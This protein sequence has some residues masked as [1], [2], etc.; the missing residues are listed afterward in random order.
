MDGGIRVP[1]LFRWPGVIHPGSVND[2]VTTQLDILPLVA[3][4]ANSSLPDTEIDGKDIVPVLQ[5]ETTHSP[6]EFVFDYCDGVIVSVRYM[7]PH[8]KYCR[9][10][11]R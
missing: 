10:N 6:Y 2:A 9:A 7:P 1:G 5:G 11:Q 4:I 8:G 3:A